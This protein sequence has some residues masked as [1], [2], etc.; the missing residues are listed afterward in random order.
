MEREGSPKVWPPHVRNPEKYRGGAPL[1]GV[2]ARDRP[3]LCYVALNIEILEFRSEW[4][5]MAREDSGAAHNWK[6]L[7]IS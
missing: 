2:N 1:G 7:P 5:H 4:V 3:L 6:L